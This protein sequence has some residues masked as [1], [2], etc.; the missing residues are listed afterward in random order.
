MLGLRQALKYILPELPD[1]LAAEIARAERCRREMQCKGPSPRASPP[2]PPSSTSMS[3]EQNTPDV[4]DR[5]EHARYVEHNRRQGSE[6]FKLFISSNDYEDVFERVTPSSPKRFDEHLQR[7]I[8]THHHRISR[9]S[10]DHE[11]AYH[12]RDD[13]TP[14]SPISQVRLIDYSIYFLSGKRRNRTFLFTS[15]LYD[16]PLCPLRFSYFFNYLSPLD[17]FFRKVSS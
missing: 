16:N 11:S 7:D 12:L 9:G 6:V 4:F 1:W 15:F 2:S 13:G 14:D 3:Q 17:F 5:N 8:F 10:A